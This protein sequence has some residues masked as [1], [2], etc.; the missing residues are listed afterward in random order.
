MEHPETMKIPAKNKKEKLAEL[1]ELAPEDVEMRELFDAEYRAFS[2][3]S[4]D[5]PDRNEDSFFI[6]ADSAIAGIFDGMGGH[7]AGNIASEMAAGAILEE[8]KNAPEDMPAGDWEG[9]MKNAFLKASREI[10]DQ[11]EKDPESFGNMGTTA[12]AVK[13]LETPAGKKAVIG[14]AGDSRIYLFRNGKLSRIT[15]DDTIVQEYID[16]GAFKNDVDLDQKITLNAGKGPKEYTFDELR[17]QITQVLGVKE[18]AHKE[19]EPRVQTIDVFPGDILMLSSDG[20]HDN[21]DDED[22]KNVLEERGDFEQRLVQKAAAIEKD[23]NN[24]RHKPDDKTT[25]IIKID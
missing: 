14:N 16:R 4:P 10:V 22:I 9:Y 12:T 24:P 6:D 1:P 2:K 8:L 17:H 23:K 3:E 21:L 19:M 11:I 25:V 20:I 18:S 7:K 13:L 5:H 15:R